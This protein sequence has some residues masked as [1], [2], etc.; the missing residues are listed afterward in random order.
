MKCFLIVWWRSQLHRKRH[1]ATDRHCISTA[2][3]LFPI[4]YEVEFL[5]AYLIWKTRPLGTVSAG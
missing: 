2:D 4:N 1:A 3:A 5:E